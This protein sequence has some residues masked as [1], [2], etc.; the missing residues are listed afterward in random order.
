MPL[1]LAAEIDWESSWQPSCSD[2]LL[3][4]YCNSSSILLIASFCSK[5]ISRLLLSSFVSAIVVCCSLPSFFVAVVPLLFELVVLTDFDFG[6]FAIINFNEYFLAFDIFNISSYILA[7]TSKSYLLLGVQHRIDLFDGFK[8]GALELQK[9]VLVSSEILFQLYELLEVDVLACLDV[10]R[11][12]AV[13]VEI[14]VQCLI[15]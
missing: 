15:D 7:L 9:S 1:A 14:T 2:V 4:R 13:C 3:N 5:L 6:L 8:I 10:G 12:S 11:L